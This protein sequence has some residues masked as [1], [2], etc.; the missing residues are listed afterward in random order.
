MTM[1][2]KL[3]S[4]ALAAALAL[5]LAACGGGEGEKLNSFDAKVYVDGLLRENY[6][7][8]YPPEYLELV[9]ISQEE[10]EYV[11]Q[12]SLSV[13]V[14][15]CL[16]YYDIDYPTDELRQSLTKLYKNIYSHAKFEVIS[17]AEQ[18]DG[19]YAV[20]V[21]VEPIDT[22]RLA[23]DKWA[24]AL[25]EFCEK[26][27]A[28]VRNA[29]SDEEYQ[30]MDKEHADIV[31]EVLQ[32]V[33]KDT[34]NLEAEE[35][36][37]QITRDEEG[38]YSLPRLSCRSS[39]SGSST[40]PLQLRNKQSRKR[41]PFRGRAAVFS[42]YFTSHFIYRKLYSVTIF[43]RPVVWSLYHSYRLRPRKEPEMLYTSVQPAP[44]RARAAL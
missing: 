19:S 43:S 42:F 5:G 30:A 27:P 44:I 10:A 35:I 7:G 37:V 29:M 34:G 38:I 36:L 33:V 31:L 39:T 22:I 41:P 6:L 12:T 13:E 1:K 4:L 28:E 8:E 26:Y 25:K 23:E 21:S 9:G 3:T 17:A 14:S 20:K 32:S 15:N 16:Y 18:E 2:K 11:Y 40:I 24:D